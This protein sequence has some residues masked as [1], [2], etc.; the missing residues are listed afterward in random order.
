[1][2]AVVLWASG[3]GFAASP[4]RVVYLNGLADLER[5]KSSNPDHHAR[6]ERIIAASEELCKPGPDQ[7]RFAKFEAQSIS[8]EGSLLRTS[9][10][11]KRQIAFTLDE[12]RYVALVTV[13]EAPPEF[14]QVPHQQA[15]PP[16]APGPG[17]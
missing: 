10:P 11:P 15:V 14:R 12:V 1:M 17:K 16:A 3:A 5:L 8:C 7:V 2:A 4:P 6:A 13:K 9:N